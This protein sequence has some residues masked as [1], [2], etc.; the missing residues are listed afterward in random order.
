M[1]APERPLSGRRILVTRSPDRARGLAVRLSDWGA[2]VEAR[3]TIELVPLEDESAAR[4]ALAD[5]DGFDWIVFTSVNGVRFFDG[6]LRETKRAP[7]LRGRVAVVGP[8]T[9]E[10]A[11][12][13]GYPPA[14]CADDGGADGLATRLSDEVGPQDRLLLVGPEVRRPLLAEALSKRGARVEEVAFYRN[15]AAADAPAVAAAVRGDRFHAVVLSSPSS[16]ER[17]IEAGGPSSKAVLEALARTR[18][19]TIGELTAAAVG[20][21]GLQVA[22]VAARPTD[23]AVAEAVRSLFD[24]GDCG[25]IPLPARRT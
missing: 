8:A 13:A 23:E 18:I 14:V 12:Q 6:M 20:A 21:Q 17:M 16:L 5:L 25:T 24:R 22:A 15:V 19:V 2:E 4:Q 3:A 10:A 11:S 9:A 1:T 7:R